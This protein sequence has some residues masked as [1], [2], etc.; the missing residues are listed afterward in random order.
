MCFWRAFTV[1][2]PYTGLY[3]I[4]YRYVCI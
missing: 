2:N 4:V 3:T 1:Y